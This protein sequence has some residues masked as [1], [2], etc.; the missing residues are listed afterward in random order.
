[1]GDVPNLADAQRYGRLDKFIAEVDGV[2]GGI[3]TTA[4]GAME[5]HAVSIYE[6]NY[7]YE[8]YILE[9][10]YQMR[11]AFGKL[12][13]EAVK[14]SVMNPLDKIS[15]LAGKEQLRRD[16]GR[17]ITQGIVR[18][19]S[20]PKTSKSVMQM[21]N[22]SISH[23]ER[24]VRTETV[25]SM[26]MGCMDSMEHAASRGLPIQKQWLAT[27]DSVTRDSHQMVDGE[28]RD[29]DEPFSNGLMFPGDPAGDASEVINCRCTM[30]EVIRDTEMPDISRR[31]K[32]DGEYSVIPNMTYNEW[33]GSRV[34]G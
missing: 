23:A 28:I 4:Y 24:I 19:E 11:L 8:G 12:N 17:A 16:I 5:G 7:Y 1:M 18:G 31:A 13:Y 20:I 9:T 26:N 32:E 15:G 34:S 25:R 33:L 3:K 22:K 2:L 29:I 30:V 6:L 27:L 10:G 21:M 14:A